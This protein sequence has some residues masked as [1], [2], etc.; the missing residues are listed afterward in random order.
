[1]SVPCAQC[2]IGLTAEAAFCWLCGSV[3]RAR[4]DANKTIAYEGCEI[5]YGTSGNTGT[6]VFWAKATGQSGT[7]SA[8]ESEPLKQDQT[9]TY[10][11]GTGARTALDH[12]LAD[13][14]RQGWE[15][16]GTHGS[17]FWAHRLR[18]P[19]AAPGPGS[20]A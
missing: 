15:H 2:S 18:R 12:L 13:L 4:T 20:P 9:G 8:A 14:T 10:L 7:Y 5:E 6:V 19:L 3:R 11:V 16:L 1:M 17:Y